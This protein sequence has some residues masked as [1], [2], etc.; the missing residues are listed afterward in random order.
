MG[1]NQIY[2]LPQIS[3]FRS[4]IARGTSD[5]TS[6]KCMWPNPVDWAECLSLSQTRNPQRL[7]LRPTGSRLFRASDFFGARKWRTC[8]TKKATCFILWKGWTTTQ[9]LAYITSRY[10]CLRLW[11][12]VNTKVNKTSYEIVKLSF[13]HKMLYKKT[14]KDNVI[15]LIGSYP[16]V[17]AFSDK[18][19]AGTHMN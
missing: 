7:E 12:W 15:N 11:F 1:S 13:P 5:I 6:R 10:C 8:G 19:V 9:T 4:A 14:W 16:R 3:L 18:S 2:Y 17:A